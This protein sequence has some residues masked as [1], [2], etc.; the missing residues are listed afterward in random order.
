MRQIPQR[1][2]SPELLTRFKPTTVPDRLRGLDAQLLCDLHDL[3]SKFGRPDPGGQLRRIVMEEFPLAVSASVSTDRP[4]I[5]IFGPDAMTSKGTSIISLANGLVTW[6]GRVTIEMVGDFIR[7]LD[8]ALVD[9]IN[10]KTGERKQIGRPLNRGKFSVDEVFKQQGTAF[11]VMPGQDP[12][13]QLALFDKPEELEII[14]NV[15]GA[16]IVHK[17]DVPYLR[18]REQVVAQVLIVAGISD[19]SQ[20]ADLPMDRILQLREEIQR[21]LQEDS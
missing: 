13:V 5:V 11:A 15:V 17:R 21:R 16:T 20:V 6:D 8:Q 19:P 1:T 10:P 7:T 4:T 14:R 12:E 9:Y 3:V 18:R 2:F